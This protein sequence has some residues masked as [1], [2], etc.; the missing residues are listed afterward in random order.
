MI[1]TEV[2][3]Q[4][5]IHTMYEGDTSTPD[6][7]SDDYL[8]RRMYI[9][10]GIG[11]WEGWR[12]TRWSELYSTLAEASDGDT[13][14]STGDTQSDCPTDLTDTLGF[15][16]IVDSTSNADNYTMVDQD[17]AQIFI[18]SSSGSHVYWMSGSPSSYK[19]NWNPKIQ[20]GDDGKTIDYPYYKRATLVTAGTDIPEPSD[21]VFLVHYA[22]HWLYKEENPG[23]S[24]E[25]LDLAINLINNMKL[26]ND[27]EKP[28][29][30]RS[31]FDKTSSGFGR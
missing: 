9:N 8:S 1:L 16:Q 3:L 12:G 23:M 20:A 17:E 27:L 5:Q 26:K 31:I 14:V 4:A 30:D 2:E 25:H 24:R 22:L 29:Q 11:F 7:S 10:M 21:H 19:I 6:A 18:R 15:V 28:Y 13:T